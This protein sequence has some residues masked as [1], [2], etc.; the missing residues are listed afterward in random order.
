V[1]LNSRTHTKF[2]E[3]VDMIKDV[4][5][6]Y[7]PYD[8]DNDEIEVREVTRKLIEDKWWFEDIGHRAIESLDI[9]PLR[10]YI[11]WKYW[12]ILA[13]TEWKIFFTP[14]NFTLRTSPQD[15]G[16]TWLWM[17]DLFSWRS[18]TFATSDTSFVWKWWDIYWNPGFRRIGRAHRTFT[19][20]WCERI[21]K[22]ES[23]YKAATYIQTK[24]IKLLWRPLPTCLPISVRSISECF[25]VNWDIW[26]YRDIFKDYSYSSEHMMFT[27]WKCFEDLWWS[28]E[29][30]RELTDD[31]ILEEYWRLS[32][33]HGVYNYVLE[34]TNTRV[35]DIMKY[36]SPKEAI[37]KFNKYWDKEKILRDFMRSI[38]EYY[39]FLHGIGVSYDTLSNCHN[40]DTTIEGFCVDIDGVNY[41]NELHN[42]WSAMRAIY[43][44][45][46]CFSFWS[47]LWFSDEKL[48]E[49]FIE[50]FRDSYY[51]TMKIWAQD[52]WYSLEAIQI[53]FEQFISFGLTEPFNESKEPFSFFLG[54]D[55]DWDV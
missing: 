14:Y 32:W 3:V 33:S 54:E 50:V 43:C 4:S 41:G 53:I 55:E 44:K 8:R 5:Y 46:I 25:D 30:L 31:Q 39:G 45:N 35:Q 36:G 49:I 37:L 34:W 9:S 51:S 42:P 17:K 13:E 20:I 2:W 16:K 6:S 18:H 19:F 40:V 29:S 52:R 7:Y 26:D 27:L 1:D 22:L 11:L 38:A 24:A 23:E 21:E 12:D 15:F 28:I 48:L 10:S 47:I